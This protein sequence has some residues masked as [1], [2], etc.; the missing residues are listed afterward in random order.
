L[1]P[2]ALLA[3]AGHDTA[4]PLFYGLLHGWMALAGDSEFAVRLPS[5]LAGILTIAI[6]LRL[7]RSFGGHGARPTRRRAGGAERV[8]VWYSQ[9]VRQYSFAHF[10]GRG[11]AGPGL[12][13]VAWQ[14]LL[15]GRLT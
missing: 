7:A 2:P 10:P 1:D 4:P 15:P 6:V 12:C 9:E 14:A 11:F 13:V 5:A 8:L 3:A